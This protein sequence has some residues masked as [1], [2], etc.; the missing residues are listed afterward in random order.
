MVTE[1]YIYMDFGNRDST[2][3]IATGWTTEES[4][5]EFR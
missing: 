5:F 4:E 2:V 1:I 3:G